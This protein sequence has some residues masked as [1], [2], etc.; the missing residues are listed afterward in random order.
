MDKQ[1]LQRNRIL[2]GL[3]PENK[4][5]GKDL[6]S[7]LDG[8]KQYILAAAGGLYA[9]GFLSWSVYSYKYN[10]GHITSFDVQYFVTGIVPTLMILY[11]IWYFKDRPTHSKLANAWLAKH[12]GLL[13][14]FKLFFWVI[15]YTYLA[16]IFFFK[17]KIFSYI[18]N[19]L[20]APPSWVIAFMVFIFLNFLFLF[21]SILQLLYMKKESKN[22][23]MDFY[24]V[25][26]TCM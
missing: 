17:E 10:L 4:S 9:L 2:L 13:N 18:G 11:F 12:P 1:I 15:L 23:V 14:F 21:N 16:D 22:T 24:I 6:L 3:Y 7:I 5:V 25:Y 26:L 19:V 20:P 8:I